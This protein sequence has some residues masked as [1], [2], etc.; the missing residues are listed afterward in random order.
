MSIFFIEGLP[1]AGK[2]YESVLRH[3]LPALKKGRPVVT[4]VPGLDVDKIK[5]HIG[6][7]TID[8]EYIDIDGP[9]K[10]AVDDYLMR[11]ANSNR[12]AIPAQMVTIAATTAQELIDDTLTP[13]ALYLL[14]EIQNYF[15]A[16]S[17]SLP[18]Q[19]I[20]FFAEHR[21]QGL[22]IVVMGQNHRD[23]HD[24]IRHRIEVL[25]RLNKLTAIGS[26]S[27]YSW[28]N[29]SMGGLKPTKIA[30]G[31]EKYD[32]KIFDLYKSHD[33]SAKNKTQY[34]DVRNSG[35]NTPFFKYIMP[36]VIVLLI[37]SFYGLYGYFFGADNLAN[38]L[39]KNTH[40]NASGVPAASAVS[41]VQSIGPAPA[42]PPGAVNLNV[43]ASAVSGV[44]PVSAVSSVPTTPAAP[45]FNIQHTYQAQKE[46]R[47]PVADFYDALLETYRARFSVFVQNA[48]GTN[49]IGYLDLLKENIIIERIKFAALVKSGYRLKL[50]TPGVR[51]YSPNGK[52]FLATSFPIDEKA[53]G[54][55]GERLRGET[56]DPTK[57]P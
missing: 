40:F 14:D 47:Y 55:R 13:D 31:F 49:T 26:T 42:L 45:L 38:K 28:T 25:T 39:N 30:S 51:I 56:T 5:Q 3:L 23:V 57:K 2:S 35:L 41:A 1:G 15:G 7:S 17:G 24:L 10:L 52:I 46:S 50:D 36:L 44:A 43:P 8:L 11:C 20:R 16:S 32:P 6:L 9:V 22:D 27:R 48:D 21:H 4:N 54:E 18:P 19:T 37:G 29:L 34:S 53:N 33:D 12:P